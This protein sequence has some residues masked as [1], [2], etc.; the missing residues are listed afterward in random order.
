MEAQTTHMPHRA[1]RA[2]RDQFRKGHISG[3]IVQGLVDVQHLA[4]TFRGG[5]HARA[6][7]RGGRHGLLAQH[8]TACLQ[9]RHRL[10]IMQGIGRADHH[11]VR[12]LREQC[13]QR[14]V[15]TRAKPESGVQQ[16]HLLLHHVINIRNGDSLDIQQIRHMVHMR[17]FSATND[18]HCDFSSHGQV[19]R[20]G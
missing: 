12:L 14:P 9:R 10:G 17:D 19:S 11:R 5:Y 13:V 3:P 1:D 18:A 16:V 6:F 4:G 20:C 15:T 8:V 2:V 7:R